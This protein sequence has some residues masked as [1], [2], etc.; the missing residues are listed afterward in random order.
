MPVP[1]L[2]SIAHLLVDGACAAALYACGGDAAALAL[3]YNTLAFSTQC[4]VGLGMDAAR[5]RPRFLTAAA[6]LAVALF[7]LLPLPAVWKIVGIGLGNSLF[8]VGGGMETLEYSGGRAAPLG[9]F[10]APGAVG[11]ALG[12]L[13]PTLRMLFAVLLILTAI[14]MLLLSR[15]AVTPA[16]PSAAPG[17]VSWWVPLLLL[18]AVAVRAVGGAA[19]AFPWKTGAGLTLLLAGFVFSGKMLGGFVCDRLGAKT[20]ALLSIPPAAVLT[21]FFASVPA[22]ALLGQL[23]L[24]LTMPVTLWLLYRALPDSPGLAF[25]LAAS[26]LWPGALLGGMIRLSGPWVWLWVVVTFAFS[27]PAI[28]IVNKKLCGK[29]ELK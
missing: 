9:V 4:L 11:L 2:N 17:G 1:A 27:L 15:R 26:A 8:H 7:A 22:A 28:L 16:A 29:G 19:A 20:A 18:L 10:V 3:L 5:P 14:G 13:Y 23:L 12:T 25:G 24:N 21:A 6:C